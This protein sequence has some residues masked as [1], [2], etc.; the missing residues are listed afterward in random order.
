LLFPG[1]RALDIATDDGTTE[2][3]HGPQR[4]Y[5]ALA[6]LGESGR[7]LYVTSNL[8]HMRHTTG[9]TAWEADVWRGRATSMRLAGTKVK[10]TSLRGTVDGPDAAA[11]LGRATEWLAS[12]GVAPASVSSMAWALWRRS[13]ATAL[14]ITS[15]PSV[16]RK[17]FYGGRQEV[18]AKGPGRYR[19]MVVADITAAYAS[20]MAARPYGLR[21]APVSPSTALDPTVAG[22]AEATVIVPADMPFAPLPHRLG[23]E[24]IQFPTGRVAGVWPWVE[25]A[26][27]AALGALVE[28]SRCWAPVVEAEPFAHW[29]EMVKVGRALGGGAGRLAKAIANSTWGLFAMAGDDRQTVR[30]ADDVGERSVTVD[31]KPLTTRHHRTAHIAAETTARVRARI[32]TEA[33]YGAGAGPVHVDT[34]GMIVRRSSPLPAP[35]GDAPG[36]WRV[37]TPMREVEI[38]APQCYRYKCASPC[39]GCRVDEWHYVT[40]GMSPE[41]A[42]GVFDRLGAGT[43]HAFLGTDYVLP[44]R[45]TLDLGATRADAHA[46]RAFSASVFGATLG[47]I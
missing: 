1:W 37:K 3:V 20:E 23:P 11:E 9:A 27:A 2:R 13:L 19:H 21:L 43:P 25:L 17:A 14:V 31:L 46:A 5:D 34:D 33:L 26:A 39:A 15:A 10:V 24:M 4:C 30:W 40:A 28:V 47:S 22:L 32:L 36:Q 6:A 29:W 16:G 44:T 7:Q 38:R 12:C 45:N 42:R 18:R 41:A 35:A 8:T